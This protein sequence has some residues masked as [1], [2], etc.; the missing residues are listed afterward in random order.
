MKRRTKSEESEI[1]YN[2]FSL[3]MKTGQRL[4]VAESFTGGLVASS[5]IAIPGASAFMHE[6]VVAYS[7]A[8]KINRLGVPKETLQRHTAVSA[9]TAYDMAAALLLDGNAD[10]VV[11]T[12]GYAGPSA[13]VPALLGDCYIAVGDRAH[14][15]IFKHKFSGG[16]E[17]I[18]RCGMLAALSSLSDLLKAKDLKE[19]P[20]NPI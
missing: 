1:I 9:D 2:A 8:A 14:I 17:N 6:A 15:H 20:I 11:A 12:T 18:M 3:L 19:K 16:R 13:P 4:S 5:L 10:V 7:D